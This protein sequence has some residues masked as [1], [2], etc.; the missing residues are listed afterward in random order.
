MAFDEVFV[1]CLVWGVGGRAEFV[2]NIYWLL[3]FN[4]MLQLLHWFSF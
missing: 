2:K 4:S 3:F 1:S